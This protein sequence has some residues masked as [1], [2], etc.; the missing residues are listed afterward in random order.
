MWLKNDKGSYVLLY[1][2]P[3]L[4]LISCKFEHNFY[5]INTNVNLN[6]NYMKPI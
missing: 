4:S 1:D 3:T 6:L 2:E 5:E